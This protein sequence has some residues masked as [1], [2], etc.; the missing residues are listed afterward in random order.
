MRFKT[1]LRSLVVALG[2]AVA[3]QSAQALEIVNPGN[4]LPSGNVGVPYVV[5]LYSSGAVG[6][7]VKWSISG[8]K[9][10]SGLSIIG[11]Q[12]NRSS[13]ITGT[14]KTSG[15]YTFVITA[16][17]NASTVSKSFSLTIQ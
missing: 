1:F 3:G 8:G 4:V 16:K 9:L 12:A 13:A 15:V 17:D 10:P 6:G 2:L 11:S 7:V 14:P 5:N